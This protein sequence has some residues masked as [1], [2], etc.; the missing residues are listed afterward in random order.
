MPK[1][2]YIVTV[3][4]AARI[5]LRGQLTFL[6]QNHYDITVITSPGTDLEA[7]AQEGVKIVALPMEREISPWRDM[8][9]LWQLFLI[10]HRLKPD[11]VNV[12]TPKAGLLGSLA[13]WLA[14]VPVR[15]Y[16]VRGLRLE[17]TTGPRRLLL[18]WTE[19]LA[20]LCAHYVVC[21][22]ASLLQSYGRLGLAAEHKLLM[23]GHGSSNGV[24]AARFQKT[25]AT[26]EQARRLRASLGWPK[27]SRVLGFVGRLTKDKGISE[28]LTSFEKLAQTQPELYLLLVGDVEEGDPIAAE[29]LTYIRTHPRIHLTGFVSEPALYYHLMDILIFPSY[30]E[31]FPNAPLEAA[32]AGLP[33]IGFDVTGVRD[34]VVHEQTGILLPTPSADDLAQAIDLLLQDETTRQKLGM[35]AQNRVRS[36]FDPTIIWLQWMNFY[37][38]ILTE[39]LLSVARQTHL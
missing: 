38:H 14:R 13:A 26:E 2:V 29:Q 7:V 20:S 16:L 5:F 32:A 30:R 39:K 36:D 22:S 31:G 3:P 9:S 35:N 23:V 33:T 34:A 28:L 11:I 8:L 19:R 6:R 1:L 21:N 27:G 37:E 24:N 4:L 18:T 15:V 12:S 17:T 10:L 25:A